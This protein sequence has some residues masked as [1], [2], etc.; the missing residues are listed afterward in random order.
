VKYIATGTVRIQVWRGDGE[1]GVTVA[2]TGPGIPREEAD[3]VFDRFYRIN[4]TR[5]RSAGGR[6]LGLAISQEI[7]RVHGGRIGVDSDPGQ[8]SR[9]SFSLPAEPAT[10]LTDPRDQEVSSAAGAEHFVE[11]DGL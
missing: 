3:H 11:R 1:V 8:G 7:I 2:D 6:R 4:R 5:A 9:F 10:R